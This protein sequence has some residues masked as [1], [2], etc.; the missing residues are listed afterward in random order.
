MQFDFKF[1]MSAARN[2]VGVLRDSD[3]VDGRIVSQ[4]AGS[5]NSG[6]YYQVDGGG[7]NG[8]FSTALGDTLRA[9]VN[10][11]LIAAYDDRFGKAA[12]GAWQKDQADATVRLTSF[13]TPLPADAHDTG[14][15]VGKRVVG[16]I[17]SVGPQVQ[18]SKFPDPGLYRQIYVDA[19]SE[20]ARA[21]KAGAMV[22]AIRL[23]MIS[24]GIYGPAD[25]HDAASLAEDAARLIIEALE[26]AAQLP[27]AS[28]L[29]AAMLVN[30]SEV[31]HP[32]NK[33]RNAFSAAAKARGIRVT[34]DGFRF[35]VA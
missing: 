2:Y 15:S 17:Y 25:P 21:N 28:H 11:A 8:L 35:E 1:E 32:S 26:A 7:V 6:M 30:N 33:E 19:F 27:D 14:A 31:A 16:L 18:G 9:T 4:D 29:P 10:K 5:S 22:E 3:L 34:S 13:Y 24:T 23:T 20:V 12:P